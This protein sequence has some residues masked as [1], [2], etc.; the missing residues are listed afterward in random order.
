MSHIFGS[1]ESSCIQKSKL[2]KL[3]DRV[4]FAGISMPWVTT[5][6]YVQGFGHSRMEHPNLTVS[7][8]GIW[9]HMDDK[10]ACHVFLQIVDGLQLGPEPQR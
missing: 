9:G 3:Q 10:E 7:S 5:L 4:D 6:W 8:I 1:M 2:L